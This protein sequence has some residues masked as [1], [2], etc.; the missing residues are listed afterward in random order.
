MARHTVSSSASRR[1]KVLALV[2]RHCS[3]RIPTAEDLQ[4][5]F[6][7]AGGCLEDLDAPVDDREE[8]VGGVALW[9][10]HLWVEG[11]FE[12]FATAAAALIFARMGLVHRSHVAG[13]VIASSAMFLFAGIPG[14]FH[15]LYFSVRRRRSWRLAQA[16][17]PWRSCRSC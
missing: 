8:G 16:S 4:D 17:A 10:I 6:L 7:A 5:D 1:G 12:V 13:A 9:V 15:H 2:D 14:T 3:Q 11:F